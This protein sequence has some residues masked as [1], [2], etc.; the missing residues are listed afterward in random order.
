MH[1][2]LDMVYCMNNFS[3]QWLNLIYF[4]QNFEFIDI[5]VMEN[6]FNF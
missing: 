4:S 2:I 3:L 6:T 5:V 1:H